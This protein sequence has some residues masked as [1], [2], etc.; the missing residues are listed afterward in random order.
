MQIRKWRAKWGDG[1]RYVQ[2]DSY[3]DWGVISRTKNSKPKYKCNQIGRKL[4]I[5]YLRAQSLSQSKVY[6]FIPADK[7]KNW[8]RVKLQRNFCF[9]GEDSVLLYSKQ[10]RC[11]FALITCSPKYYTNTNSFIL[12]LYFFFF[13]RKKSKCWNKTLQLE[14]KSNL[15]S[16]NNTTN[17]NNIRKLLKTKR[18]GNLYKQKLW[19]Q[20]IV[21]QASLR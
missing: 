19:K 17:K 16:I 7:W 2:R 3:G 15:C 4:I 11:E 13:N 20:F 10:N 9:E 1:S 18:N 14:R 5:A 8:V 21:A 6:W 12:T